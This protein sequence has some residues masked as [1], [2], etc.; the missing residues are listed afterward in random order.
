[1]GFMSEYCTL[2][3]AIEELFVEEEARA[4]AEVEVAERHAGRL[5]RHIR[6]K[7]D[8]LRPCHKRVKLTQD[9][10]SIGRDERGQEAEIPRGS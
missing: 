7:I 5:K 3:R 8:L 10:N 6:S 1:M 4:S 9:V 2:L